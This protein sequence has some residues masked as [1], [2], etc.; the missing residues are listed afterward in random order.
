MFLASQPSVAFD[1]S[2]AADGFFLKE[3]SLLLSLSAGLKPS[4]KPPAAAANA[5]SHPDLM[6]VT[7][8]GLD[9]LAT[10]KLPVAAALLDACAAKVLAGLSKAYGERLAAQLLVTESARRLDTPAMTP[11]VA[12]ATPLTLDQIVSYQL[13]LW[14]GIGLVLT[15]LSALCCMVGMEVKPDSLLYAKFTA[16]VSS[17]ME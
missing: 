14:T 10:A 4:L 6:L 15:L 9:G 8:E 16:D 12:S 2:N 3:L 1:S 17:K 11:T 13:A 7:L 5:G